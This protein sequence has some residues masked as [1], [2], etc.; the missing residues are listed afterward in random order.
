VCFGIIKRAIRLTLTD[1]I[2]D[3]CSRKI[4]SVFFDQIATIPK[5]TGK[6]FGMH[7]FGDF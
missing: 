7:Y 2:C 4:K 6:L 3:L 1:S 5:A